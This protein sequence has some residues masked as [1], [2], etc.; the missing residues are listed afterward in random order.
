[1]WP[2]DHANTFKGSDGIMYP[3][4]VKREKDFYTY[5]V[6]MCRPLKYTYLEDNIIDGVEAYDFHLP[7]DVFYNSTFNPE[8]EGY[9]SGNDC[10]GNGVFNLSRCLGGIS[11]FG[12]LPHFLNAEK[13]IL[14]FV[15]GLSP[16]EEE[17]DYRLSLHP[18][19]IN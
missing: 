6:E 5:N 16:N 3:P 13:K 4:Y 1:M 11:M 2:S 10:L 7:K 14:D 19:I 15:D 12:S 18:V 8:N 17:H 9:C